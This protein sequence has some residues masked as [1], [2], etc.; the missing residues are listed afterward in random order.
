VLDTQSLEGVD[1]ANATTVLRRLRWQSEITTE[2]D[3]ACVRAGSEDSAVE[4]LSASPISLKNGA[5]IAAHA[6][7]TGCDRTPAW[8]VSAGDDSLAR[9]TAREA[10]ALLIC[11][12]QRAAAHLLG[13]PHAGWGLWRG[14]RLA[15]KV[16]AAGGLPEPVPTA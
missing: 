8:L 3:L 9:A 15:E 13:E 5:R 11:T 6:R 10:A 14:P 1:L 16:C 12:G 2:M 4:L 7:L